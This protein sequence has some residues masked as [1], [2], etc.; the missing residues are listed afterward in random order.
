MAK[1]KKETDREQIKVERKKRLKKNR[2]QF[3]KEVLEVK[4]LNCLVAAYIISQ[5]FGL[6]KDKSKCYITKSNLEKEN[7][8]VTCDSLL[9]Y[10]EYPHKTEFHISHII[11]KSETNEEKLSGLFKIEMW[12]TKIGFVTRE[13]KFVTQSLFTMEK[14]PDNLR[15]TFDSIIAEQ[16]VKDVINKLTASVNSNSPLD[17][18][19]EKYKFSSPELVAVAYRDSLKDYLP[20]ARIPDLPFATINTPQAIEI[21]EKVKDQL[22][23]SA[24]TAFINAASKAKGYIT[25]K[26]R[27]K[28]G[29]GVA[30]PDMRGEDIT[31]HFEEPFYDEG[32]D[33]NAIRNSGEYKKLMNILTGLKPNNRAMPVSC[34][35]VGRNIL[36][37][38]MTETGGNLEKAKE[39]FLNTFPKE[40]RKRGNT[41]TFHI[42]RTIFSPENGDKEHVDLNFEITQLVEAFKDSYK[43]KRGYLTEEDTD[44]N[45][46]LT[47]KIKKKM[48]RQGYTVFMSIT[49]E[50]EE[51][52]HVLNF[53]KSCLNNDE[54]QCEQQNPEPASSATTLNHH[55]P[56]DH[57]TSAALILASL[58]SN[59]VGNTDAAVSQD[60]KSVAMDDD[61]DDDDNDKLPLDVQA[62]GNTTPNQK[63]ASQQQTADPESSADFLVQRVGRVTYSTFGVLQYK[64]VAP[65]AKQGDENTG[66]TDQ[67]EAEKE[68]L[69]QYRALPGMNYNW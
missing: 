9:A 51:S 27:Q 3:Q 56:V 61:D 66:S 16:S 10:G 22:G 46:S 31:F 15:P 43:S 34:A 8:K 67:Q 53:D 52:K 63:S 30:N 5:V 60:L 68:P 65:T 42:T 38:L 23:F 39:I 36:F 37:F 50:S 54:K 14:V 19:I 20:D 6:V 26:E 49:T 24:R 62:M 13:C 41:V 32:I 40:K 47:D 57:G 69:N 17:Q 28:I 48:R 21:E 2:E 55:K 58:Y 45:H 44:G 29:K 59:P 64:L 12:L 7:G 1:R 18:K 4:H 33:I 11:D 25:V 35:D